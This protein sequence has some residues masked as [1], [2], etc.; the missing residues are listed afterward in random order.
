MNAVWGRDMARLAI[1]MIVVLSLSGCG[2]IRSQDGEGVSATALPFR[3]SLA[4]GEDRRNVT[5]TV[6]A[7]GASLEDVRETA[8]FQVTRYCLSTFGASDADWTIDTAT[9][10]WSI[11]R[12][13]EN[14]ILGARCTAR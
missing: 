13:G 12:D 10:D 6:R 1:S 2:L 3:A 9:G 5:V 8:R 14:V 4:R 11:A 7:P